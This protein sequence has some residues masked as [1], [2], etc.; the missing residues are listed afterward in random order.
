MWFRGFISIGIMAIRIGMST[1]G[2]L[3]SF[4]LSFAREL[5]LRNLDW[6]SDHMFRVYMD[7]CIVLT[8]H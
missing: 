6:S 5:I 2:I 1:S 7:S 8:D 4:F 3:L